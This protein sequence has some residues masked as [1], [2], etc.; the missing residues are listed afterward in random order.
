MALLRVSVC[1]LLMVGAS[2]PTVLDSD[3]RE[4]GRK[5]KTGPHHL[6]CL[7]PLFVR[8]GK[9]TENPLST[10]RELLH[11][12]RHTSSRSPHF[13]CAPL[14]PLRVFEWVLHNQCSC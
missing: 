14:R 12:Q 9:K 2:Y 11:R 10:R 3:G 5:K 6:F 1:S 7:D 8:T 13:G 4:R